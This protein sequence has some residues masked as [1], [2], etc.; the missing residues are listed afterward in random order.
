MLLFSACLLRKFRP[1]KRK[2]E[3]T[4]HRAKCGEQKHYSQFATGEQSQGK[5][6]PYFQRATRGAER[7][8]K[9]KTIHRAR[10][11]DF[12]VLFQPA[13]EEQKAGKL[14]YLHG[15]AY[16]FPLFRSWLGNRGDGRDRSRLKR[17]HCKTQHK[18]GILTD[19]PFNQQNKNGVQNKTAR[20][21]WA[22]GGIRSSRLATKKLLNLRKLTE[23]LILANV[24]LLL[25]EMR[26]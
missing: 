9:R 11:R 10:R 18:G 23:A 15:R 3:K 13:A 14:K 24:F 19:N 5:K 16:C 25:T 6:H 17:I 20:L 2:I 7:Q 22:E 12:F 21:R 1:G 4:A 8:E 26:N